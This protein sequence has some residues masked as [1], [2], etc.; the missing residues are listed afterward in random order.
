MLGKYLKVGGCRSE[1][2][3]GNLIMLL[4]FLEYGMSMR[5]WSGLGVVGGKVIYLTI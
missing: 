3:L 5:R 4:S 1:F 2:Q